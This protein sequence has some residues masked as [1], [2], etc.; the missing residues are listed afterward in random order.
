[1]QS[2][3]R[4]AQSLSLFLA[5]PP[6]RVSRYAHFANSDFLPPQW[7]TRQEPSGDYRPEGYHPTRVGDVFGEGGRYKVISK[8]GWSPYATFWLSRDTF[9]SNG[10]AVALKIMKADG[11]YDPR[12]HEVED[13]QLLRD[14]DPK[15]RGHAHVVQ[16]LDAFPHDGPNGKHKCI[17]TEALCWD[18]D[19]MAGHIS[20]SR[21]VPL[22]LAKK[23]TR[24][25]LHALDYAHNTCGIIHTD[26]KPSNIMLRPPKLELALTSDDILA[27]KGAEYIAIRPTD[28]SATHVTMDARIA[29]LPSDP[30]DTDAWDTSCFKL[31]EFTV[32]CRADK[33]AEHWA[34]FICSPALRPPE[35]VVGAS[36]GKPVDIW[37]LGCS[38]YEMLVG[39]AML[40]PGIPDGGVPVMHTFLLG[41]YPLRL[42]ERGQHSSIFF[43]A[44][45]SFREPFAAKLPRQYPVGIERWADLESGGAVKLAPDCVHFLE[46]ML[47]FEP[48]ERATAQE[49]LKH[50]FLTG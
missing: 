33:T 50:P 32:A 27:P 11:S 45:G 20:P 38:L 44:D 46:R 28:G 16:L 6:L 22:G 49:L 29:Y 24:D 48:E 25:V 9:S 15:N 40:E 36:W 26:V 37:S 5:R 17:I 41:D 7:V 2:L 39:K 47:A 42:L 19:T 14:K 8:L 43:N 4:R 34:Q 31:T 18:V 35:V 3:S 21:R 1:M 30:E 23:I 13:L 10:P 12:L